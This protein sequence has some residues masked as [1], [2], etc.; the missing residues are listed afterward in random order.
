[1]DETV[2]VETKYN[3]ILD[4]F[5]GLEVDLVV[6]EGLLQLKNTGFTG[7]VI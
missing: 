4:G 6:R 3:S 5:T 1:M 7:N 2:E